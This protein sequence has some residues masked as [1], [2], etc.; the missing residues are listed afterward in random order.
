MPLPSSGKISIKDIKDEFGDP[1]GDGQFKFSEYYR[2]D[3]SSQPVKNISRN[4]NVPPSGEIRAS[5]FY[6]TAGLD[7]PD[8]TSANSG[9]PDNNSSAIGG[10]N[11]SNGI[12]DPVEYTYANFSFPQSWAKMEFFNEPLNSRLRCRWTTGHSQRGETIGTGYF[13]YAGLESA[14]W[15]VKY[16]VDNQTYIGDDDYLPWGPLPTDNG[17]SPGVYYDFTTVSK[18]IGWM[19]QA[20]TGDKF[21]RATATA[22]SFT[23]QGT[24]GSDTFESNFLLAGKSSFEGYP[25][26][27]MLPLPIGASLTLAADYSNVPIVNSGK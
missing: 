20:S 27:P 25:E 18:L 14:T 2:G 10:T 4:S 24:L 8:E 23:I 15:Q 1:D 13:Y 17:F 11:T 19:C 5:Q 16:D 9:W 3:G 12:W 21:S 6:D 26:L 7:F 22:L